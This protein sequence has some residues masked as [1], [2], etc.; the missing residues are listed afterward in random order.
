MTANTISKLTNFI[1]RSLD[2][3]VYDEQAEREHYE[4]LARLH[5]E[6]WGPSVCGIHSVY[7]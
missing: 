7:P 6:E 5:K 4:E 1:K 2:I 3:E